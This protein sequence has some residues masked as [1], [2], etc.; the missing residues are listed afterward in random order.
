MTKKMNGGKMR[1]LTAEQIQKNYD[2]LINSDSNKYLIEQVKKYSSP[3]YE[4]EVILVYT[5]KTRQK[6]NKLICDHLN[7]S[8][9]ENIKPNPENLTEGTSI[10]CTDRIDHYFDHPNL[11]LEYGNMHDPGC[12]WKLLNKYKPDEIY[13]IAAQSH[14]RV[15]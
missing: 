3:V 14:V 4:A 12:L 7:I 5:N 9:T 15:F 11:K 1:E 6:Y 10:I 2:T 8:Y 13:N